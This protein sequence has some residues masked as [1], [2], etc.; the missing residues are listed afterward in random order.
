[1]QVFASRLHQFVQTTWVWSIAMIGL[2]VFIFLELGIRNDLDIFL[3]ASH[4]LFNGEAIYTI[5]YFDGFH[6]YYSP[7]FATLIYPLLIFP[8]WGAKLIWIGLNIGLIYRIWQLIEQHLKADWFNASLRT[9]F[10]IFLGLVTLRFLKAN[11]HL[12]QVTIL[13]LWASMESLFLIRRGNRLSGGI[14]LALAINIKILPIVFWPYLL[15]RKEFKAFTLSLLTW[16]AMLIA[17]ALWLGWDRQSTLIREWWE[18][19]NP[20]QSAHLIDTSE[21][22]FHSLTT[23]LPTLL[24]E[25]DPDARALPVHRNFASLTP[26]QVHL[27][28]NLARGFFILLTL[29]FLRTRPFRKSPSNAHTF[30]ETSYLFLVIP[31]IFPHQ[32]Q[33]AFLFALPAMGWIIYSW[34][35]NKIH[36]GK[37]PHLMAFI[38]LA[39]IATAFN[40]SL[41]I[42]A[43]NAWYNHFKI[44]TWGA[45]LLVGLLMMYRPAKVCYFRRQELR[46]K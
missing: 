32:Q 31:L 24:L 44:V 16:G 40:L 34:M 4:G 33:Y 26:D 30:W 14:L 1:M 20:S 38:A 37:G 15:W 22:S 2:V 19:V 27:V 45:L 7:L 17:P 21:T 3:A 29:W 39:L 36:T 6:Y 11:V 12:G 18:L 8:P 46:E 13:L 35:E 42:G 25:V 10:A 9:L 23:L 41:W 43:F 5:T 28:I